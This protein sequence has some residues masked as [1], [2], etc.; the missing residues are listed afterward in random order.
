MLTPRLFWWTL[1][2]RGGFIGRKRDGLPGWQTIWKGWSEVM[3]LVQ[4]F[5]IHRSLQDE[6]TCG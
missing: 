1:A 2:Q 6:D 3:A 5:E 4:G